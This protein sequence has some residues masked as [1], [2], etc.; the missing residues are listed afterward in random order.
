MNLLITLRDKRPRKI[1]KYKIIIKHWDLFKRESEVATI[2]KAWQQIL[3]R[4]SITL[5]ARETKESS[6]AII[7]PPIATA[8]QGTGTIMMA[9]NTT[10]A[11]AAA[12]TM[13]TLVAIPTNPP[14]LVTTSLTTT[15]YLTLGLSE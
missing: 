15:L 14:M 12:S 2:T 13:G 7:T 3:K 11:T 4:P 6:S 9:P 1:T 5:T 10:M 8:G